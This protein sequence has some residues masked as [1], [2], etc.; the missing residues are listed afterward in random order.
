MDP[1][2]E[3]MADALTRTGSIVKAAR[4]AEM[5]VSWAIATE[6][7]GRELGDG[8]L[9]AAIRDYADYWKCS[10]RT[11]WNQ[12]RR[13]HAVWPKEEER[14]PARL[15]AQVR[16]RGAQEGPQRGQTARSHAPAA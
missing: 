5:V 14:S 13:F 1:R 2:A 15:A 16:A 4:A 10:E 11:A 12:L 7:R 3:L 9:S 6:R 8:E